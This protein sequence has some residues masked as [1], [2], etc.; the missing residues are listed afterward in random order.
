MPPWLAG[1]LS[2]LAVALLVAIAGLLVRLVRTVGQLEQL[3]KGY[4]GHGGLLQQ[5][6]EDR[7]TVQTVARDLTTL[8]A[9]VRVCETS[10]P[11]G[12]VA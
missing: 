11:G 5:L 9:R 3:L 4:Q 2:S 1:A 8:E 6:E 7:E 12:L 10:L